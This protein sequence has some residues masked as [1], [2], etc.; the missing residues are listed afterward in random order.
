MFKRI[1]V[2]IVLVV[3]A[4]LVVSCKATS[5]AADGDLPVISGTPEANDF[6]RFTDASRIEGR[7]YSETRGD[8]SLGTAATRAAEDSM[9]DGSNL[10]DGAAIKAYGDA[11][12]GGAAG[13][14]IYEGDT[15]IETIDAGD[16][17]ITVEED[18]SEI[19]RWTDGNLG[20]KT[21]TPE[22][23][24]DNAG[25]FRSIATGTAPSTG[26]GIEMFYN[27]GDDYG[28]LQAYDRDG[29]AWKPIRIKGSEVSLF[30]GAAEILKASSGSL[31]IE[32]AL[33]LKE[34]SAPGNTA[35]YGKLYVKS[36]DSLLYFLEDDNTEH[37]LTAAGVIDWVSVEDYGA[38][39]DNSTNDTTAIN[40][41][42]TA[43]GLSATTE[44]TKT[45]YFPPGTYLVTPGGLDEWKC[46][47]KADEAVFRASADDTGHVVHLEPTSRYAVISIRGI[48]GYNSTT[49]QAGV[50]VTIDSNT[51]GLLVTHAHRSTIN[52]EHIQGLQEAI[53]LDSYHGGANTPTSECT[54]NIGTLMKNGFGIVQIGGADSTSK[55]EAN[56]FYIRYM[57]GNGTGIY[58]DSNTRNTGLIVSNL[59]D[60]LAFEMHYTDD[61]DGIH[62]N[63]A[64]VY[65]NKFYVHGSLVPPDYLDAGSTGKIVKISNGAKSNY[66]QLSYVDWEEMD[67]GESSYNIF[68]TATSYFGHPAASAGDGRSIISGG[69]APT[70]GR[71]EQGSICWRANAVAGQ[72][73]G[74]MCVTSGSPGTWKAMANLAP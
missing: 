37:S 46:N 42:N 14:N 64:L 74:W 53:R 47:V 73:M 1:T 9:T 62:L 10:P 21:T 51:T 35:D 24:L 43:L 27:V 26:T 13:D 22:T 32:P 19:A 52:I 4:I 20:I 56:R 29:S 38:V 30:F 48:L 60:I 31:S 16:G 45:L 41:A 61:E 66:F 7:S 18:G 71:W 17:Y 23:E 36:S 12:W 39:G 68:D 3:F 28:S 44:P 63:G 58:L 25:K 50:G 70:N 15:K 65:T 55:S 5:T 49:I 33:S 2:C 72:M 8:L 57:V 69:A 59:Y 11:N 34:I 54:Y 40:S 6:A 67:L